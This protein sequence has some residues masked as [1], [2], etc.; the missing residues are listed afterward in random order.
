[1]YS[2]NS[3]SPPSG[4]EKPVLMTTRGI[5]KNVMSRV[6]E[7]KQN[8]AP[9]E[10]R[11]ASNFKT[12]LAL[13]PRQRDPDRVFRFNQMISALGILADGE[14]HAFHP[15]VECIAARAVVG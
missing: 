6:F 12:S 8:S 15:S 9:A 2:A 4:I 5:H 11:S 13:L 3:S 1:M 7:C 14:F 10:D